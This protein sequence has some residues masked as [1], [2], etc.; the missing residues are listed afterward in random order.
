MLVTNLNLTML[1][2]PR[3]IAG[4]AWRGYGPHNMCHHDFTNN[5]APLSKQTDIKTNTQHILRTFSSLPFLVI[6]FFSNT[7]FFTQATYAISHRTR[8]ALRMPLF[9]TNVV[10]MECDRQQQ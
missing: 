8:A 1:T 10:R 3:C 2:A 9:N 7:S 6:V 4:K 5:C